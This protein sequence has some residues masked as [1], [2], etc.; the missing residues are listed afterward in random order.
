MSDLEWPPVYVDDDGD[1]H[2]W[3]AM[4]PTD[5]DIE[6][7]DGDPMTYRD[8]AHNIADQWGGIDDF[9]DAQWLRQGGRD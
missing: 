6:Y 5:P 2:N 4:A 7:E 8:L 9:L 3:D 1:R